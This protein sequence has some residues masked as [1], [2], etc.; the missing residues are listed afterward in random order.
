MLD[1][2]VVTLHPKIHGG[3]LA[4]RGKPSHVADLST[5]ASR[6]STWWC[7]TSTRSRESPRHRDH[8]RRR[9]GDDARGGEEPRLGH[10]SS[11]TRRSTTPCSRS[12]TRTT[13]PLSDDTRRA[14]ALEAF[15][16]TA[17]YDAAIV[18]LAPA[19]RARCPNTSS[20]RS[21]A[22]VRQLRYGENPH[23]HGARATAPR[24]P[25]AGGTTSSSTPAL[26][27]CYLNLYDADAAW[28]LVHDLGDRAHGARSS[29][30]RTRVAS[31]S[32][33]TSPPR[34]N[35]RSSATS[36]PRSAGSWR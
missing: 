35:A 16:S 22:P 9:T 3:I 2:R 19:R 20:S 1:H 29:S 31:R 7:A 26:A 25:R 5:T 13:T 21:I 15:A 28:R 10:R 14:L 24:A 23:Q 11:P 17:A 34:T 18:A 32:P 4:D 27:L 33:T 6:R 36:V 12:S 8:R 30:T